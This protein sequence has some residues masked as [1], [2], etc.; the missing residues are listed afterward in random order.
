LQQLNGCGQLSFQSEKPLGF[1]IVG[2]LIVAQK[3]GFFKFVDHQ[4]C[5]V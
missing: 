5:I 1:L 4:N 3:I 2:F